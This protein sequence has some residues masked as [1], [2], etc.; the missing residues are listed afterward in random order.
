MTSALMN[1]SDL[2]IETDF[3]YLYPH[4]VDCLSI[5]VPTLRRRESFMYKIVRS[6]ASAIVL[7]FVTFLIFVMVRI[8]IQ[9]APICGWF[10]EFIVT[11]SIFLAQKFIRSPKSKSEFIWISGLL[12]FA[13]I[14]VVIL[15]SILYQSLV[16]NLY[17]P[18]IDTLEQLADTD[19]NIVMLEGENAWTPKR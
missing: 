19:L 3:E 8:L 2:N 18:E 15:S 13:I 9:R 10:E 11:L 1:I 14:A 12:M 7:I 5:L 16:V 6:N 17:E 4:G